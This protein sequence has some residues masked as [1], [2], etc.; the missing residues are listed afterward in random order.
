MKVSNK[1]TK[2][3]AKQVDMLNVYIENNMIDTAA[4]SLSALIRSAMTNKSKNE[5][6]A[7]A[8]SLKLTN[9]PDFIC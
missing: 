6:M 8:V 4:R 9:H 2:F 3:Q 7:L 1:M 5:L